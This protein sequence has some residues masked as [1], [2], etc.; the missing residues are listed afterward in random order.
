MASICV[1]VGG[2]ALVNN[3]SIY[4]EVGSA[5]VLV[6]SSALVARLYSD[7]GSAGALLAGSGIDRRILSDIGSAGI[8]L[9]GSGSN[10][11]ISSL[12]GSA[13]VQLGGTNTAPIYTYYKGV[14]GVMEGVLAAG[15]A[16]NSIGGGVTV[17]DYTTA[18]S[19]TFNVPA[20]VSVI[21][22]EGLGGG[23][24]GGGTGLGAASGGSGGD[25]SKVVS[26]SVTPSGTLAVVVGGANQDSYVGTGSLFNAMGGS[27]PGLIG[28]NNPS[29]GDVV[30]AGGVQ[31]NGSGKGNVGGA[32]GG[33]CG[34]L[35]AAGNAGNANSGTT[36]G[37]AP[38]AIVSLGGTFTA[39]KGG[40]YNTVSADNGQRG[41]G[42][43]GKYTGGSNGAGGVGMIRITY[44]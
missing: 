30:H 34:G 7:N 24:N 42:G 36:G 21:T 14:G 19:F 38:T 39:G 25:Y 28:G 8:L 31:G 4:N 15:T 33:T 41:C 13:G 26:Y 32:S 29:I 11:R 17:V 9:A 43:G 12:T 27:T 3:P 2:T 20:G 44:S 37:A 6:A 16:T 10:N 5:G 1:R 35:S 18:G 22:V 23:G 40:T